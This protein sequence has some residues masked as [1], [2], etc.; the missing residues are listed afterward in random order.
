MAEYNLAGKV[1]LVTGGARG[2]GFA[3]AKALHGRGAD[4][5]IVDLDEA[6][7]QQSAAQIDDAHAL[8]IGADVTDRGA[9]QR[10]VATTVE[11]F[12]G[13]DV[14]MANA[15]IASRAATFRAM[16]GENIERTLAVNVGGVANTVEAALPEIV[17]RR[18]HVVVVASIYAFWNGIGTV[19]YAMSKAGV[20]AFCDALRLEVAHTGTDVGCAYFSFI[21]TDMVRRGMDRPSAQ[22]SMERLGKLVTKRATVE[23]A[24]AAITRGVENR[25]KK[26][27]APRWV[28]PALYLRT[29][30]QPLSE[31]G[32][33]RGGLDEVIRLAESETSDLTTA[34]PARQRQA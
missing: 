28:L 13:L 5:V 32:S 2:I 29:V 3:T 22:K 31:A 4:V 25:A 19:P 9:M 8:G 12:G 26:V 27:Y 7:T 23:T 16:S 10:V 30:I 20:E 6:A 34:Q 21:D 14:V 1:A 17:P 15:G 11:R 33:R 24:G 18:G